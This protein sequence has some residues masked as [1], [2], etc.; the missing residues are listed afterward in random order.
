MR[1]AIRGA[2]FRRPILFV[3]S[4]L[5]LALVAVLGVATAYAVCAPSTAYSVTASAPPPLANW[6]TT[7][8]VWQP[9]GGFPGCATNDSASDTNFSPTTLIIDS[10]I[11]N[12]IVGLN[13]NCAGCGIFIQS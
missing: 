11:P 2:A 9:S 1:N 5:T 10:S 6:T 8:G 4:L 12:P 3:S 13:L 7:V